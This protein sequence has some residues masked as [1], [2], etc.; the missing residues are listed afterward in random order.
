[1]RKGNSR[2]QFFYIFVDMK[3]ILITG[4][5][6]GIGKLLVETFATKGWHVMATDVNAPELLSN[7]FEERF[8][9][10]VMIRALNVV[11]YS[12]WEKILAET[13]S[14]WGQLDV[15]VNNAGVLLPRHCAR[16][17]QAEIDA[18][19]DINAKGLIYGTTLGAQTMLAKGRGHIVNI[20]SIA[21]IAPSPGLSLYCASKFAARGFTL[22][23]AY[24]LREKGVYVTAVCPDAVDT[25]MV[26]E[27]IHNDD[28][29]IVFSGSLLRP[30]AVVRAVEQALRSKKVEIVLPFGRGLAAKLAGFAPVLGFWVKGFF[31]Q[32]G[33]K[34]QEQ[35]R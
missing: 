22:S 26:S 14:L 34:K 16:I 30:E 21:G 7:R 11:D 29:S 25:R 4:C 24:E 28:A 32:K 9:D 5:A 15:L 3:V 10:K 35:L 27:H 1:M 12:A 6:R 17:A 20:V 23:V 8:P 13:L 19:M 33:K 31:S 18:Q 2:Q